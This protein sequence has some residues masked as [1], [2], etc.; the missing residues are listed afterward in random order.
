MNNINISKLNFIYKRIIKIKNLLLNKNN[1]KNYKKYSFLIKELSILLKI[2]KYI[3]LIY[4]YDKEL[5]FAISLKK[6]SDFFLLANEEIIN[7][8]LK[9]KL[10][11]KKINKLINLLFEEKNDKLNVY[12]EIHSGVGGNE[13][14]LFASDLFKM[15][16]NYSEIKKWK[17]ELINFSN[18]EYGG[19]KEI[20]IKIIGKNVYKN[21]KFESGG[22]R[23]QR[24]PITESQGRIHTSTCTVAVFPDIPYLKLPI[25][26]NEDIKIDTFKSSGA[27]GQHVNTTDSAIRIT[28]IPTNIIVECQKERSQHKNKEKALEVLKARI[29]DLELSKRNKEKSNK[30]K[31]L[32][33]SGFRCDRN[34]T[35]NFPKN[36]I[37]DHR[38]KLSFFYL[39]QILKGNMD[40]IIEPIK[41]KF[42]KKK[43][44]LKNNEY[45]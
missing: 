2:K 18:N 6:Q 35:Y 13:A 16:V 29:Y 3:N 31:I 10:K 33:G 5:K 8:Q 19:Y 32:L 25:I 28:H 23:V 43:I 17:V 38:F 36:R 27:G 22:H 12:L 37:T 24:I 39:N 9:K 11:I 1:L 26:K 40:I 21:L 45:I 20:I 7:L 44:K 30:R 42:L 41:I 34:R 15:Y 4:K 14:S